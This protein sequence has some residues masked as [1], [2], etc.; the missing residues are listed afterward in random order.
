MECPPTVRARRRQAGID[1]AQYVTRDFYYRM[2][3]IVG[4]V[5][6]AV[7]LLIVDA[8]RRLGDK[9]QGTKEGWGHSVARTF[10]R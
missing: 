1:A 10:R 2:W 5:G 4:S 6:I 7:I 9:A 3:T 8:L